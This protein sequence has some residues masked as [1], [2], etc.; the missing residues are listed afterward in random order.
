MLLARPVGRLSG[1]TGIEDRYR[2]SGSGRRPGG[3]VVREVRPGTR[4]APARFQGG[5][6][7]TSRSARLS[8]GGADKAHLEIVEDVLEEPALVAGE[9]S[10]GLVA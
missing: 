9:I 8:G 1:H 4:R 10:L 2:L 3:H 5:Y 7:R 6:Q